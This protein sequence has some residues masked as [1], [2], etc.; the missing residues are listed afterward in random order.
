MSDEILNQELDAMFL[1]EERVFR[2]KKI[3][4]YTEGSRILLS[5]VRD[6]AD[7]HLFFIWSFLFLHIKLAED[8]RSAINLVWDKEKF[9]QS[10]FEFLSDKT[11]DDRMVAISLVSK[12][13]EEANG[14][15]VSVVGSGGGDDS[16]K[17]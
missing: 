7:S 17:V 1:S 2:G 9:R 12:I 6:D 3:E 10:V 8:R 4:K 15:R 16:G 13:I 5:Q 11:E 14:S